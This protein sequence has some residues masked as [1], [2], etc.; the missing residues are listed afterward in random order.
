MSY[1]LQR[2]QNISLTRLAASVSHVAVGLGWDANKGGV[3]F[4]LDSSAFLLDNQGKVPSDAYFIFYNQLR[5]PDGAV[6]HQGNNTTGQ[7]EGDDEVVKVNLTRVEALID[8]IVF[9]VTIY[10]GEE[11]GQHF[12]QVN[13]AYIRIVNLADG[14]EMARYDLTERFVNETAMAFGELYRYKGDWKFRAVGQGFSGG[15]NAMAV[16]YGVSVDE[17]EVEE[18]P[19]PPPPTARATPPAL[20]TNR[21]ATPIETGITGLR[22]Q[23]L[24]PGAYTMLKTYLE[25]GEA[26]KAEPDSMIA[27][28]GH[29]DVTGGM[30]GG[31][32]SGLARQFIIGQS[33]FMQTLKAE[34]GPGWA[35]LAQAAPGDI[36][37]IQLDGR[38][39]YLVQKGG[40]LASTE[41]VSFS[42]TW[43]NLAQG[44]GSGEG[45]FVLKV[46]GKGTVFISS[47]GA[48]HPIDLPPGRDYIIDNHHLV[49]WPSHLNY[50]IELASGFGL[51][52]FTSGEMLVCRFHGPGRVLVQ[53]RH[54][55]NF[56]SWLSQFTPGV[57]LAPPISPEQRAMSAA[58]DAA[59][60]LGGNEWG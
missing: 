13:N 53:T 56:I 3:P 51:S 6:E 15:L 29:L 9:T 39:E 43:Q 55:R 58:R 34:R 49:A 26:V 35:M 57:N 12:G 19:P 1:K 44:L 10:N 30:E 32:L 48:I 40:Y 54:D 18:T 20:S 33:F 24:Y 11:T 8:K 21:V 47:F 16:T 36:Q 7:G 60:H 23:M 42:T 50:R 2:G 45:L 46:R 28:H 25:H 31:I 52:S 4:N 27:M 38:E 17:A 59:Q 41:G 37:A 14:Q 22:Y 5:S